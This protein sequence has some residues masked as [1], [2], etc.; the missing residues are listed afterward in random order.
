MEGIETLLGPRFLKQ[1][2][3]K[4]SLRSLYALLLLTLFLPPN[5]KDDDP[6]RQGADHPNLLSLDAFDTSP[7]FVPAFER[8]REPF[9]KIASDY[10]LASIEPVPALNRSVLRRHCR[11]Q[12]PL[13]GSNIPSQTPFL[14]RPPPLFA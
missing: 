7:E 1:F 10:P 8:L 12:A 11:L 13:P 6:D 3:L 9:E 2:R 14:P 4:L 5:G